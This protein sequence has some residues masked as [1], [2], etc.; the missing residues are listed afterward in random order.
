MVASTGVAQAAKL[1]SN[2]A[3]L[4]ANAVDF[5]SDSA[6]GFTTGSEGTGY[7]VTGVDLDLTVGTGTPPTFSVSIQENSSG[8]PGTSLGTLTA[9]A[10]LTDNV[11]RF[12]TAGIRLAPDTS[13][14]VVIDVSGT[15]NN[16]VRFDLTDSGAED[17]GAAA[18]WS[19]ADARLQRAS[20]GSNA[21]STATRPGQIAIHG[22]VVP[23]VVTGVA[24]TSDPGADD[25]YAK[26]DRIRMTVTFNGPVTVDTRGGTPRLIFHV[27]SGLPAQRNR[28]A[29]YESGSGTANI[30]FTYTVGSG[31]A[32]GTTSGVV[33]PADGLRLN[34][35]TIKS[36]AG[37]VDATLTHTAVTTGTDHL[38]DGSQGGAPS[39]PVTGRALVGTLGQ[40]TST[41]IVRFIQDQAQAFTTGSAATGY[42]L[43]GVDLQLDVH[44]GTQPSFSVSIHEDSSGTPG[45]SLGTLTG[46]AS[47]ADGANRFTTAG[48]RL[49]PDTT[50]FVVIDVSGA[51]SGVIWLRVTSSD[52]E[53]TG[54]EAGWSIADRR[55]NRPSQSTAWGSSANTAKMAIH[56]FVMPPAVT[57]VAVTSDPGAD[58]TYA[59][60]DRIRMTVTFDHPVTVNTRGGT[61]HLIFD[62]NSTDLAQRDRS[63]VYESGSGTT[64]IVFGYTVGTADVSGTTSGV[65]LRADGLRLYGGTI[66]AVSG[67]FDATLTYEAVTTGTRH[68]VNGSVPPAVTGLAVTSNPG[69]D[70]TYARLDRIR[71]TVTFTEPVTVN[72]TDGTPHLIFHVNGSL[73]AQRNRTA[74]Y[75]SGSGTAE[76][77][78]GYTVGSADASGTTSGV[79]LPADGLR[80][81]SATIKAVGYDV[82]A[83]LAY[84]AVATGT[85]HL[86]DGSQVAAASGL[87]VLV[88]NTGRS[89]TSVSY[90]SHDHAQAFTTGSVAGYTLTAVKIKISGSG[91]PTYTV[92]IRSDAAGSPGTS[93]GTLTN[94]ASL[95]SGNN[96]F[97]AASG[98]IPLDPD[99]TYWVVVDNSTNVGTRLLPI[100]NSDA[101]DTGAEAGWSIADTALARA[102][103]TSTWHSTSNARQIAIVG[104]KSSPPSAA[105]QAPAAPSV[106]KTA[107]T[108]LTVTWSAPANEGSPITDYDVRYRRKGDALWVDHAHEGT[109][110]TAT[111][112]GLIE[113]AIYEAQVRASNKVGTTEWSATGRGHTGTA[114]LASA[115]T[116]KNGRKVVVTF[117][118]AI[119]FGGQDTHY[120]LAVNGASRSL[121]SVDW[122]G[123]VLTL[124]VTAAH[125][126]EAGDSVTV[127]YV[128][129][130]SGNKLADA[131]RLDIASFG[132]VTVTNAVPAAPAAPA[133]PTVSAVS[134]TR[135]LSVSWTAPSQRGRVGDHRLRPALLRRAAPIRP[136]RRTGSRRARRA[137]RR[138]RARRPRGPSR[139]SRRRPPTGCRCAR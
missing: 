29:L 58:D 23:L 32:S 89:S 26:G 60:G 93:L 21:W 10:S 90:F 34:G 121:H 68:K 64:E 4:R 107:G 61:P 47:V 136:T 73:Q 105:P 35:G 37:T 54:A 84:I 14:F 76:I 53:D 9:P 20:Q 131:D 12:S 104:V 28:T 119:V 8:S 56:G 97:P 43:T 75:E 111:I 128:R 82:D 27:N 125:R 86:V 77:V 80:L 95:S 42:T 51:G 120:V 98:G 3:H 2:T 5:T 16:V 134:G 36:L 40:T 132:P 138:T 110:V 108:S 102:F 115:V 113:G 13:Y 79:V 88:S 31:D 112:T 18:G 94:P 101:E 41:G 130:F 70:D 135:S 103:N 55:L 92:S 106:S 67:R 38:V 11:N 78:F 15:G 109:A 83:N 46:P 39:T 57:G 6:Q 69:S 117:T 91:S 100:T 33:V 66:K 17:A 139:D 137:A 44:V 81:N 65:A 118:K 19:I 45:T 25:T 72:T 62:V 85:D 124:G 129:P 63:A 7:T 127:R 50:Y 126:I 123:G 71:M 1:V 96:E 74:L 116:S 133:A 99:T 114:R 30:V 122:G 24:V 59:R 49:A 52:A 48:I 22:S 87:G